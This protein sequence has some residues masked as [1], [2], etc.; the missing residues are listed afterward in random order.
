MISTNPPAAVS[1]L[2]QQKTGA[3]VEFVNPNDPIQREYQKILEEDDA[4]QAEVDNWI[5]EAQLFADKGASDPQR[6]RTRINE[7]FAPV[8]KLYED[9]LKRHPDHV[10][11]LL[12]YGS[13]LND[14]KDEDGAAEQWEKARQLDPKNP[15]AWND[16]ATY[17]AHNSPVKKAF[18]YFAKA[19]ELKP[20]ETVYYQN[21]ATVVY[22]YRKDA[23][24]YYH[25]SET[26]VFD[27]ALG[28]YRQALK[29]SPDN[30]PLATDYAQSFYSTKPP[31]YEDGLAAW[32]DALKLAHDEIEKEGVYLHF[33]RI[34]MKLGR[35]EEA[36]KHLDTVTNEMYGPTKKSLQ[37][38]LDAALAKSKTNEAP[39]A[40]K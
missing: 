38:N 13:F 2:V 29:L 8:K 26:E 5:R 1:N 10:K 24:E 37:R 17:Y 4:S 32:N 21:F 18:E 6:L 12:A 14:T 23:M 16:L 3:S 22:L 27:K 31:R 25:I 35:L 9:F 40:P 33:A 39:V 15:A 30:F 7:R 28:L 20:N 34:K 11:A 19:L 36:Q